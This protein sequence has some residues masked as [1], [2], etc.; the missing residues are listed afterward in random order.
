MPYVFGAYALDVQR[1]ERCDAAGVIPLDRQVFAV[2]AYLVR[3]H[4]RVVR[5]QLPAC[6]NILQM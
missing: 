5:R 1:E 6:R 4:D 3:H 2:L